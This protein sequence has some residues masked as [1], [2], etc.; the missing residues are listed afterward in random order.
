MRFFKVVGPLVLCVSFSLAFVRT[1]LAGH[2]GPIGLGFALAGWGAFVVSLVS[3]GEQLPPGAFKQRTVQQSQYLFNRVDLKVGTL[4]L[5][6][7]REVGTW[8]RGGETRL[9]SSQA[10]TACLPVWVS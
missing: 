6:A 4:L 7:L 5:W 2:Y 3:L 1:V 8:R 10:V 9:L